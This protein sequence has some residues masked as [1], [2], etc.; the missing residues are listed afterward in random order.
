MA[1]PFDSHHFLYFPNIPS[2]PMPSSPTHS[3]GLQAPSAVLRSGRPSVTFLTRLQRAQLADSA[4]GLLAIR[5]GT[6]RRHQ[7]RLHLA[8]VGHP[9]VADSQYAATDLYRMDTRW[10]PRQFLHRFSLTFWGQTR[11]STRAFEVLPPDLR[12]V[13]GKA[14]WKD[15]E[16]ELDQPK[17]WDEWQKRGISFGSGYPLVMSTEKLWKMMKKWP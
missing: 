7:I 15:V 3:W 9:V 6:G 2:I 10:C 17:A 1:A 16:L 13:L 14:T 8:H 11:E 12:Q 5:I 4:C